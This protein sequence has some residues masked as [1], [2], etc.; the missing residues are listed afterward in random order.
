[1]KK[2][3]SK[4]ILIL[5][6]IGILPMVPISFMVYDLINQSYR[7]GVN[8]QV[9]EALDAGLS[10]SKK[11]YDFQRNQ[12][13]ED[14]DHLSQFVIQGRDR[15]KNEAE[16][17][18][19]GIGNQYWKKHA[20]IYCLEDGQEIWRLP[21]DTS[22]YVPI[23]FRM[24]KEVSSSGKGRLI[25]SNRTD[26]LYTAIQKIVTPQNQISFLVLQAGIDQVVLKQSDYLLEITQIYQSLDLRRSDLMRSFF[27]AF[28]LIGALLVSIAV[29]TGIWISSRITSPI[30]QVVAATAELGKGNL[31]YRLPLTKGGDEVSQL[32]GH[33]NQMA[34]KLKENQDRLIYLEKR[35][36][37]QQMARKIAH[38][39]KNPL[40]PIQ[41]TIQQLVDKYS[42]SDEDYQQLL[43]EC[44][45][46]IYEEI[47]S[48]R[49]LVTEFSEFGRLPELQLQTGNFNEILKEISTLYSQRVQLNL[50]GNLPTTDFDYD[51]IRRVLI[52]L[53]EN[54]IQADPDDQPV[55]LESKITGQNI[56]LSVK[57]L[58]EGI[59][60]E[61]LNRIFE[62]YYSTKKTGTGLGLAI[63]SLIIEEHG[64]RISVQSVPGKGSTFILEFPVKGREV[65]EE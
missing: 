17:L 12:L 15:I 1:M 18:F 45:Q 53:V 2:I 43:T 5:L 58:G 51:R 65:N 4:I 26:N 62:P 56:V 59:S 64:G 44:A 22:V 32:M 41:L 31:D 50:Q 46:I 29:V 10:F 6:L 27:L 21:L 20:L 49:Q 13:S 47:G 14:V 36:A 40:T 9:Q 8:T 25:V 55:M 34:Q 24:L 60:P 38:E 33:F 16:Q 63:S 7:M 42:G 39:I 3:R 61:N 48:L 30:S 57:D 23:D 52:N 19:P 37:W 54:A 11:M 28:I 35:A